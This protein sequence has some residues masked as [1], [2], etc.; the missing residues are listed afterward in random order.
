MG[1]SHPRPDRP[2][3][4]ARSESALQLAGRVFAG[5]AA[6]CL[7]MVLAVDPVHRAVIAMPASASGL[8][9]LL[10]YRFLSILIL[11]ATMTWLGRLSTLS[12]SHLGFVLFLPLFGAELATQLEALVFLGI[13]VTQSI[14]GLASSL[15]QSAMIAG[16]AVALT[17]DVSQPEG[18]VLQG[19]LPARSWAWRLAIGALAYLVLFFIAGILILPYVEHAYADQAFMSDPALPAWMIP[20]ELFRGLLLIGMVLPLIRSIPGSPWR[21]GFLAGLLYVVVNGLAPLIVPNP[22]M[23]AE[24]RIYHLIEIGCSN[25]V[26]GL[27]VGRL[28]ITEAPGAEEKHFP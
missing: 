9:D 27:I 14:G 8:E 7:T 1:H 23:S 5:A 20:L 28:F 10:L 24:V 12:G 13:P 25:F 26:F 19:D 17:K 2:R 3:E 16:V 18:I 22:R 21:I 6:V 4:H 11:T 15:V